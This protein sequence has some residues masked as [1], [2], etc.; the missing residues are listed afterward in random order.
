MKE[1]SAELCE[2]KTGLREKELQLQVERQDL[3][4]Q[5]KQTKAMLAQT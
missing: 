4:H 3:E 2:L 5:L 1:A